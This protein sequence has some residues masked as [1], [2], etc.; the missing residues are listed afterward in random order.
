MRAPLRAP[1]GL[2][3]CRAISGVSAP[4]G[5]HRTVG[6]RPKFQTVG[7]VPTSTAKLES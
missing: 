6:L 1:F 7:I 3:V 5:L 4:P 2:L